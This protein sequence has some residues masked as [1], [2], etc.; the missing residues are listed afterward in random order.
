MDRGG[1]TKAG[2][3]LD[4]HGGRLDS[5]FSKAT[6]N[7]ASKNAQGQ[8]HLND[9]LTCPKSRTIKDGEKGFEIFSPDGRAAY[10]RSDGSFRGFT[11]YK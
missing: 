10:F 7:P 2:R 4:K 5:V 6:G 9:I 8:H 11:E 3:A 1:L